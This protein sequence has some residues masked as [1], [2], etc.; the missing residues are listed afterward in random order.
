[1]TNGD[2]IGKV[3]DLLFS[4]TKIVGLIIDKNGWLNRHLVVPLERI[5]AI[6][7]DAL[8]IEDIQNLPIYDKKQFPFHCLHNG[9]K[10]IAGKTLMTTK[11]KNWGYLEDVYFNENG[12]YHKDMR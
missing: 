9:S 12:H 3:I 1:M 2:E 11:V 10:R 8:I 7:Q 4:E 6:G 5:H